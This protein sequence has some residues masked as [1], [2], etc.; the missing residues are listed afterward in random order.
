MPSRLGRILRSRRHQFRYAAAVAT[1]L[2]PRKSRRRRLSSSD[3]VSD[4]YCTAAIT[5]RWCVVAWIALCMISL[6]LC[7]CTCGWVR[8]GKGKLMGL[9]SSQQ[10][11][12]VGYACNAIVRKDRLHLKMSHYTRTYILCKQIRTNKNMYTKLYIHTYVYLLCDFNCLTAIAK[13]EKEYVHPVSI[14]NS[15]GN[16][17]IEWE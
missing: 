4:T 11:F 3:N 15:S 7:Q 10:I 1:A 17:W 2:T 8:S 5:R 12:V 13:C 16:K 6:C 9:L 14:W